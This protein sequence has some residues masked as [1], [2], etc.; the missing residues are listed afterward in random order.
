[1][2]ACI[3][4]S[5]VGR[6]GAAVMG[7]GTPPIGE[8]LC[9]K[10]R[11]VSFFDRLLGGIGLVRT[12]NVQPVGLHHGCGHPTLSATCWGVIGSS[13]PQV[14]LLP[15]T[16]RR[17]ICVLAIMAAPKSAGY[18]SGVPVAGTANCPSRGFA[19]H[20]PGGT[21]ASWPGKRPSRRPCKHL[22]RHGI[23]S[24]IVQRKSL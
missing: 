5:L 20:C 6:G 24:N 16:W 17:Y 21:A 13:N 9:R 22:S 15:L 8:W 18:G 4:A 12:G 7:A 19:A 3:K 14:S 23:S 2:P 1:M 10:R 11:R